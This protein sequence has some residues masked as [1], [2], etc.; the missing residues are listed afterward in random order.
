MQ[1]IF[2]TDPPDCDVP[3]PNEEKSKRRK[4]LT[5]LCLEYVEK[6]ICNTNEVTVLVE[7]IRELHKAHEQPFRCRQQD[8]EQTYVYHSGRV[9]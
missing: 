2:L 4:W 9:K 8:C 7:Q 1:A 3:S 6:Y 5:D